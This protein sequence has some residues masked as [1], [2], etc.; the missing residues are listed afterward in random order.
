MPTIPRFVVEY[1]LLGKTRLDAIER[2]TQDGGIVTDVW[3][4][5]APRE[6]IRRSKCSLCFRQSKNFRK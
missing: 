3:L 1:F 4:A 6:W 5:F 2:Y